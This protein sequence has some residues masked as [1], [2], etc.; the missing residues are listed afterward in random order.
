MNPGLRQPLG[1]VAP[2]WPPPCLTASP[3]AVIALSLTISTCQEIQQA[4]LA[5]Q[6][7]S[8]LAGCPESLS[9]REGLPRIGPG[10]GRQPPPKAAAPGCSACGSAV[11]TA[12]PPPLRLQVGSGVGATCGALKCHP[13]GPALRPHPCTKP[14]APCVLGRGS[15]PVRTGGLTTQGLTQ[16]LCLG[17]GSGPVVRPCAWDEGQVLC[18]QAL[19]LG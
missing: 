4:V 16:A 8:A 2:F 19:C 10:S 12:G 9:G 13:D 15:G 6:R 3:D 5:K 7:H 1:R 17:R 11:V 14:P 18:G